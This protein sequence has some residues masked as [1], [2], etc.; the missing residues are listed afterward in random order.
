MKRLLT[1]LAL[2]ASMLLAGAA[3]ALAHHVVSVSVEADCEGYSGSAVLNVFDNHKYRVTAPGFDTGTITE[4]GQS[5]N[6]T[7][8][9][10]GSAK[11]GTVTATIF[12]P[13]GSVEATSSKQFAVEGECRQ[14][15][16]GVINVRSNMQRGVPG[17]PFSCVLTG[18][19]GDDVKVRI[20][21]APGY[22]KA[23]IDGPEGSCAV[24]YAAKP[25][26]GTVLRVSGLGLNVETW[27][28]LKGKGP[29]TL[30]FDTQL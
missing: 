1:A 16:E 2:S 4:P 29:I 20:T 10:S 30:T 28:R 9:F 21:R 5:H 22:L 7:V 15:T 19:V 17:A 12:Y 11:S 8:P 13:N 26:R 14:R 24:R 23:V 27:S 25:G 18:Y 6:V 3:P